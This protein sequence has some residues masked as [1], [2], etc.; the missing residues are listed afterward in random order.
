MLAY[1]PETKTSGYC[2]CAG[3]PF[4][5]VY[6]GCIYQ[7]MKPLKK[8]TV[9]FIDGHD[10]RYKTVDIETETKEKAVEKVFNMYGSNFEHKLTGIFEH[11]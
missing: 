11:D 10:L 7:N 8:Y 1:D 9:C 3:E 2:D 6:T 5:T 4:D